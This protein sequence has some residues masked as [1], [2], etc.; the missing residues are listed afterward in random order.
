MTKSIAG[1]LI[2]AL[3]FAAL[4]AGCALAAAP[5]LEQEQRILVMLR[6]ATSAT[7]REG[8]PDA[9]AGRAERLHA[10]S[11]LASD[12]GLALGSSWVMAS[13]QID[14]FLMTVPREQSP[15]EAIKVLAR[16]PRVAWA[17][18]VHAFHTLGHNDPLFR[19]Q[20]AAAEW[21][22]AELHA[23]TTGQ[24]VSIA[25]PDSG[26]ELTHPDLDGQVSLAKNFVDG[27]D[28]VAEDHGTAV[29]GVIVARADNGAGI[30]GVAPGARLMALRAC[31]QAGAE[32][33]CDS[34]SLAKSLQFALNQHADVINLSLTGPDD[35]LL[36]RLLDAALRQGVT[37]VAAADA[38]AEAGGFPASHPG[39]I[40]VVQE[41]ENGHFMSVAAPG[42][43]VPTTL[44][45]GRWGLASGSSIAAAH[46]SGM[47][48]LIRQLAPSLRPEQVRAVL[49]VAT[50]R[51]DPAAAPGGRRRIDACAVIAHVAGKC[52]CGC[53]GADGAKQR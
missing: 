42:Q 7:D 14:C 40:A 27:S 30:V 44:P 49:G 47:V 5:P 23:L 41:G 24:G 10:A 29:A 12:H 21:H 46:V 53:A 51:A 25:Q 6:W 34:F 31:E 9:T 8:N 22:L 37:V 3:S 43:E 11:Q 26:V 45:G 39:A 28:Y 38:R 15:A 52:A 48:A 16:E 13:L 32:A 50:G 19:L 1:A 17:Q 18:P 35:E 33:S 4:P 2:L 20:P 36:G